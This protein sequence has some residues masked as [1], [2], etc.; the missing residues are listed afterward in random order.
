MFLNIL[1]SIFKSPPA[2]PALGY[3]YKDK[4]RFYLEYV[5]FTLIISTLVGRV[6]TMHL[7]PV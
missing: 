6:L 2:K 4:F 5:R 3:V 1:A 7:L